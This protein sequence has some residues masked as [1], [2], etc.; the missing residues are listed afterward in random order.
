[1][2]SATSSIEAFGGSS[3]RSSERSHRGAGRVSVLARRQ[4]KIV[5][6]ITITVATRNVYVFGPA[7]QPRLIRAPDTTIIATATAVMNHANERA[8]T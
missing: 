8:R 7:G 3:S 5:M 6:T 2:H 4:A 1:M